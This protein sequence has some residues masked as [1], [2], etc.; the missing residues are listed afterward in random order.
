M[1]PAV[2]AGH[3][4]DAGDRPRILMVCY[5]VL[6]AS[7]GVFLALV[8]LHRAAVAPMLGILVVFGASRAFENPAGQSLL[9]TWG[10]ATPTR[11]RWPGTRPHGTSPRSAARRPEV[12]CFAGAPRPRLRLPALSSRRRLRSRA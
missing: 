11:A 3:V 9:P 7:A 1:F 10:R 4:A 6:L 5:T 12:C 8:L 2:F